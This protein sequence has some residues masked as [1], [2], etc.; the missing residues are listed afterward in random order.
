MIAV[1]CAL[2]A[3]AQFY[4]RILRE[5]SREIIRSRETKRET[6][7]VRERV[8]DRERQREIES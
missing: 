4:F 7:R 8:K 3:T 1:K 2:Q 6:D 5:R